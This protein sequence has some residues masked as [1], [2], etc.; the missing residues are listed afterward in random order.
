MLMAIRMLASPHQ[1]K[2]TNSKM[3]NDIKRGFWLGF[4]DGLYFIGACMAIWF[5]PSEKCER[6]LHFL[7]TGGCGKW[8]TGRL[9]IWLYRKRLKKWQVKTH[10][11]KAKE[12]MIAGVF[13]LYIIGW[14]NPVCVLRIRMSA[15]PSQPCRTNGFTWDSQPMWFGLRKWVLGDYYNLH[16][17]RSLGKSESLVP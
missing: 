1:L 13:R 14:V 5:V 4:N 3:I 10:I 11:T 8:P 7:V 15:R 16:H 6:R 17:I 2:V 9:I 12:A